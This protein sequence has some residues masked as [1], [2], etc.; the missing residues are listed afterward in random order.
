M[1]ITTVIRMLSKLM[2]RRRHDSDYHGFLDGFLGLDQSAS[3][4]QGK[5]KEATKLLERGTTEYN[6]LYRSRL[7]LLMRLAEQLI[8]CEKMGL[9]AAARD[10]NTILEEEGI[11]RFDPEVGDLVQR[12]RC[13]V[14]N[15]G[16]EGI[17]TGL[18]SAVAAPGFIDAGD[19]VILPARVYESLKPFESKG[20]GV[21]LYSFPHREATRW[22]RSVEVMLL[23]PNA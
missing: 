3:E 9:S 14:M 7:T 10:L 1:R 20:S 23:H 21:T 11:Q 12:D 8:K 4:L 2:L 18:V 16:F 6:R 22:Q 5:L 17:P 13:I 19:A 15:S